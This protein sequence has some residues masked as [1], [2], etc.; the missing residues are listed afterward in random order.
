MTRYRRKT[1]GWESF[2]CGCGQT[3][4]LSPGF[5]APSIECPQCGRR[6]DIES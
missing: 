4:Q 5:A 2:K 6:I 3:L 1:Q